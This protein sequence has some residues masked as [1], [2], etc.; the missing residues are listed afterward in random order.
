MQIKAGLASVV[1]GATDVANQFALVVVFVAL[2]YLWSPWG[3]F[4]H[5]YFCMMSGLSAIC[6][7]CRLCKTSIQG[8]TNRCKPPQAQ[9]VA[10]GAT[11]AAPAVAA[12]GAPPVPHADTKLQELPTDSADYLMVAARLAETLPKAHLVRVSRVVNPAI[13]AFVD[14]NR[15]RLLAEL[16]ATPTCSTTVDEG[17]F[18]RYLWHGSR[19]I[20]PQIIW[21]DRQDGFMTQKSKHGM[22]GTG[23]YFAENANYSASYAH[24]T[25]TNTKQMFL[26][27]VVVGTCVEM[28]PTNTLRHP[29]QRT[30]D[31]NMRYNTV[32]G[33][34]GGSKVFVVYEGG[35]A[36]PEFLVEYSDTKQN[37]RGTPTQGV[38]QP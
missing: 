36:F 37:P 8:C 33:Q 27:K 5:S 20:H 35:R 4:Y 16:S 12:T 3:V 30:D 29:P 24:N 34:T 25:T 31:S 15:R 1:K 21:A 14:M 23:T 18:D 7:L 22:W 32:C 10:S 26:A 11:A 19:G 2:A 9:P 6:M 13:S 38:L 17:E 28:P